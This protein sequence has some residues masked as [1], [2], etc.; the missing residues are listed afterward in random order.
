MLWTIKFKDK[1]KGSITSWNWNFGDGAVSTISQPEHTYNNAGLY[2]VS[3]TIS[4]GTNSD[5]EIK[6]NCITVT[7]TQAN[8]KILIDPTEMSSTL[9]TSQAAIQFLKVKNIGGGTLLWSVEESVPSKA[10]N[11]STVIGPSDKRGAATVD[12]TQ[13]SAKKTSNQL[14]DGGFELGTPNPYWSES[15][16]NFG[17]VIC[18]KNCIGTGTTVGP[19]S[20][21][22]WVWFGWASLIH[23]EGKLSQVIYLPSGSTA[24]LHF[25]IKQFGCDSAS[26]YLEVLI[27]NTQVFRTDGSNI[28]LC[29]QDQYEFKTV[30][31]S[32]LADGGTHTLT[33]HS[34][35]FAKNGGVSNFFID[36]TAIEVISD[37]TGTDCDN[38]SDVSWLTIFP[39]SGETLSGQ[40]TDISVQMSSKG[41]TQ[42]G[43]YQAA[44]C[45]KSND[46]SVPLKSVPVSMTVKNQVSKSVSFRKGLIYDKNAKGK[47]ALNLHIGRISDLNNVVPYLQNSTVKISLG[48]EITSPCYAASVQGSEFVQRGSKYV[49]KKEKTQFILY[50]Q[51]K[52]F[53]AID[54]NIDMLSMLNVKK[55]VTFTL[56]I[57]NYQY[58]AN[59]NWQAV[60]LSDGVKYFYK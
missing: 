12:H 30:N 40:S 29:S 18:S 27:D 26:D 10:V 54:K 28:I 25:Y 36:D 46:L 47:D 6:T 41:I 50:L 11:D 38:P 45:L 21:K 22:Y 7:S 52:K 48:N 55:T 23:E 49:Y 8:P 42:D 53:K 56:E 37:G 5:T 33:F 32:G 39:L 57:G 43:T 17:T 44:L 19:L 3:L 35:T 2:T 9:G 24:A 14:R 4:D 34:E 51:S 1:S 60:P 59:D 13:K 20:G 31:L 15:S 58:I 16:T